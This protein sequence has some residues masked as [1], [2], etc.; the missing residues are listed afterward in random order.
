LTE[1]K[2]EFSDDTLKVVMTRKP[3]CHVVL[4]V[5]ITPQSVKAAWT[6]AV[7]N[8]NKAV[9]LP[10]FRKGRAPEAMVLKNYQAEVEEE[11]RRVIIKT[12]FV[13][14]MELTNVFP[15]SEE[16]VFRSELENCSKES[17]ASLTFEYECEPE[18]PQVKVEELDLQEVE[19]RSIDDS[20]V[21]RNF[22]ALLHEHGDW[23]EVKDRPV[24]EGDFVKLDIVTVDDPPQTLSQ[25]LRFHVADGEMGEWMKDLLIGRSVGESVEG[26][27]Q[28]DDTLSED[29]DFMPTKLNIT[30]KA[31]VQLQTSEVDDAFA[32]RFGLEDV[33]KM[34]EKLRQD[35]DKQAE[36]EA[37]HRL[38]DQLKTALL[39]NYDFD[40]PGSFIEGE[41]QFLI[42]KIIKGLKE[43]ERLSDEAIKSQEKA[44]EEKVVEQAAE[45]IR[46]YFL[47]RSVA[48]EAKIAIKQEEIVREYSRQMVLCRERD[49]VFDQSMKPEELRSRLYIAVLIAKA[50]EH[51]AEKTKVACSEEE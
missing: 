28:R 51:L 6:K 40:V 19:K 22:E 33:E 30:V 46:L 25:D 49:R 27:S 17:G 36:R 4:D 45:N 1:E 20:D 9:S 16:S 18:V 37:H 29:A 10:G 2:K 7:K 8:V 11:W 48:Q 39:D 26:M 43:E 47:A 23:T 21:E 35:L 13:Q 34:K 41:R 42:K 24:Q 15:L 44:I 12:A 50:M 5:D 14:C 31:I 38:V 32:Q 3:H